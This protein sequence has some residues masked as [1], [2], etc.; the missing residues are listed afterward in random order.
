MNRIAELKRMLGDSR[1]P[2]SERPALET[3]LSEASRLLDHT[4]NFVPRS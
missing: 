3:E 2:Q 1:V 4:E